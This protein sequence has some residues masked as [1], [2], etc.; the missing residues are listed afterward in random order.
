M[1]DKPKTFNPRPHARP[2]ERRQNACARGYDRKWQALRLAFLQ[3]NPLCA[4]C[5]QAGRVVAAEEVDHVTPFR[6]PHDP[7]RLDGSNLQALCKACHS[8]KTAREDGGGFGRR[9]A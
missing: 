8:A 2:R 1:P 3:A 7:L 4:A 6:G 5:W 9:P